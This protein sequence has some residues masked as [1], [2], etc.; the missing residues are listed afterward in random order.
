MART[1]R[2]R[3][4]RRLERWQTLLAAALAAVAAIVVA[5]IQA[6]SDGDGDD[7]GTESATKIAISSITLMSATPPPLVR[8]LGTATGLSSMD[9]IYVVAR[10]ETEVEP[11]SEAGAGTDSR[12]HQDSDAAGTGTAWFASD[13]ARRADDGAWQVDFR[14][15]ADAVL[16]LRF[17][18]VIYPG[19]PA[20]GP[21]SP[22][23]MG[24]VT[25]T[26]PPGGVGTSAPETPGED[27]DPDGDG[28]SRSSEPSPDL[29]ESAPPRGDA[30]VSEQLE[31]SGPEGLT[32][33]DAVVGP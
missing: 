33:S 21:G 6:V 19:A 10:P 26:G 5:V 20:A 27:A 22:D 32:S 8:I 9:L 30:G 11:G 13:P 16:P 31:I 7:G 24:S 28:S 2:R 18:A 29:S 25:P 12:A 17:V 3:P 15:P 4:G 1:E 14:L 23:D